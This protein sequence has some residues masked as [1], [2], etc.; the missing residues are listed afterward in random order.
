MPAPLLLHDLPL[1]KVS[2]PPGCPFSPRGLALGLGPSP[3]EVLVADSPNC[4][5]DQ[6]DAALRLYLRRRTEFER[7]P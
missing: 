5:G 2:P 1:R 6:C 7:T 3:L 4:N